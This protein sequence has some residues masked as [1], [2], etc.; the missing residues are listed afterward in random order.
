M[1]IHYSFWK[2]FFK[3]LD[4]LYV[5]HFKILNIFAQHTSL[6]TSWAFYR[7]TALKSSNIAW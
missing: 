2:M 5:K 3:T 4:K 7:P 1:C 6:F